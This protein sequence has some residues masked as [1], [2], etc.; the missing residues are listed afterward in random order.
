MAPSSSCSNGFRI[1]PPVN[2]AFLQTAQVPFIPA[3]PTASSFLEVELRPNTIVRL[4][5]FGRVRPCSRRDVTRFRLN[6]PDR[7]AVFSEAPVEHR[8]RA[9]YEVQWPTR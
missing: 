4:L 9:Q 8:T 5:I 1:Y 6:N 7:M 3:L 2:I